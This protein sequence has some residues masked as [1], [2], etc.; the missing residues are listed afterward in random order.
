MHPLAPCSALSDRELREALVDATASERGATARVVSLLAEFDRRRLY[1]EDGYNSLFAYCTSALHLSESAAYTRIQAARASRKWP[2]VLVALLDGSVTLTTVGILAP[3]FTDANCDDLLREARHQ[4]KP[5]V[6][7]IVARLAP[8]PDVPSTV[9]RIVVP[10][11]AAS[12]NAGQPGIPAQPL[13]HAAAAL[14]TVRVP[15]TLPPTSAAKP[16][17]IAP[18]R[19]IV[20]PLAPHRYR[21]QVTVDQETHDTLR[22]AQDLMRHANPGGDPAVIISRALR[23]LVDDLLKKRTAATSRPA[24]S[25]DLAEGSRTIPA[26]VMRAVWRRDGGRCAFDGLRGRCPERGGLEYHHVIPYARGGSATAGNIELRCR[27]H[28]AHQARLDG[29]GWEGRE[30][31]AKGP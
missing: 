28:N 29:L 9:R 19:A 3:H 24:K 1:L 8:Q 22:Q 15:D 23:L 18:P 10:V 11:A 20:A 30:A 6:Q 21:I 26:S 13:P 2:N 31:V 4:S 14:N 17:T 27:A 16:A 25:R 7:R 5:H 12:A